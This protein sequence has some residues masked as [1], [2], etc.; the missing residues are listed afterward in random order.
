MLKSILNIKYPPKK[1]IEDYIFNKVKAEIITDSSN[2]KTIGEGGT[3]ILTSYRMSLTF[4]N[5]NEEPI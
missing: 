4:L 2:S 3:S 1:R 5:S